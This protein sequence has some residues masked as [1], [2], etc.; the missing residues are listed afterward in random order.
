[1]R[2]Q[3]DAIFTISAQAPQVTVGP[4]FPLNLTVRLDT[5]C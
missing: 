2:E 5:L 4:V 1:M 3:R